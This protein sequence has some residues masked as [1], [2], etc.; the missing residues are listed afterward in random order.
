MGTQERVIDENPRKDN[1]GDAMICPAILLLERNQHHVQ[2]RR[3]TP[4]ASS[5]ATVHIHSRRSQLM[6]KPLR[7]AL[8]ASSIALS[9][10]ASAAADRFP[11]LGKIPEKP[12]QALATLLDWQGSLVDLK[13][14]EI[15]A[16]F[17]KPYKT[18]DSGINAATGKAMQTISYRLSRRSELRFTIH[19]GE[20]GAVTTILLPSANEDGPFDD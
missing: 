8:I 3:P 9:L 19:K 6:S 14:S 16:R 1:A 12:R 15:E 18:T 2:L 10:V 5:G 13:A 20:V 4:A 7:Y 17:G 11:V